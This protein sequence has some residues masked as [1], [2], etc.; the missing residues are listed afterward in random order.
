[1]SEPD[2]HWFHCGSCGRLFSGP[3]DF[4]EDREC[5]HCGANPSPTTDTAPPVK[6]AKTGV[7]ILNVAS[8]PLIDGRRGRRLR[9]AHKVLFAWLVLMA[10]T[11]GVVHMIKKGG[12]KQPAAVERIRS[13]RE[14]R[15]DS[16]QQALNQ[17]L[18]QCR[19]L[20]VRFLNARSVEQRLPLVLPHPQIRER[21]ERH[22]EQNEPLD[23]QIDSLNFKAGTVVQLPEGECILTQWDTSLGAS[24][25]AAFRQVEGEWRLDW[26]HFV[27]YSEL[28]WAVFIAG[29]GEQ[30]AAEFRLHAR[31]R[32]GV[33]GDPPNGIGV[34]LS[35]PMRRQMDQVG[36]G[37]SM[38]GLSLNSPDGQLLEQA[39]KLEAQDVAILGSNLRDANPEAMIR[40]R[41][42]VQRIGGQDGASYRI[43][44]VLACHWYDSAATG[45]E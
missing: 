41:V 38:M 8:K 12:D 26:N 35:S 14:V 29:S 1:M 15:A 32:M 9:T 43:L 31:L 45:M 17:V 25:D 5:P 6:D 34:V 28:S 3:V 19:E 30:S 2:T 11:L 22:Y 4:S 13:D 42:K 24:F 36:L 40:V 33:E 23:V 39:F 27:R 7:Q 44:K 37:Q 20:L 18:P 21:M 10:A 16:A